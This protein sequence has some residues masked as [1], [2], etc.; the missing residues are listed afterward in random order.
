MKPRRV[1]RPLLL[2]LLWAYFAQGMTQV[3]RAAITFDEGPHL[4]IGYVTLRTGD[5]RLQPIHIHPPLANVLAAAPLLLQ[6]D[7][8]DPRQV[9]GW[10]IA[11]L[12][13][14]TDAIVWQ[15]AHPAHLA[16]AGRVPILLLG[17]LLGAFVIRWARELG[18]YRAALISAVGFAFD[19]NLIAHGAVI[20]TDMAVTLLS[21]ATLYVYHRW[22]GAMARSSRPSAL[23][24][25]AVGG[26]LGLAQLAKVSALL[27]IPVVGL[28]WLCDA[29]R[30]RRGPGAALVGELLLLGGAAFLVVWGGYRF[31]VVPV[32]GVPFSLPAGTHL[33]IYQSLEAH[34]AL[35]HPT[36]LA[37]RVGEYGW[38]QYFPVAFLLKT[39]LPVLLLGLLA[40]R[41]PFRPAP[42]LAWFPLLYVIS[43]LFSS[44]DIGYRHL[45]PVLPFLYVGLGVAWGREMPRL[46]RWGLLAASCW[47]IVGT[48]RTLPYPLTFFNELAG[49]PAGGY[50]YLV[51]SNLDW[52]QNLWDLA[53]W[54]QE[55]D[56]RRIAYAHYSPARPA[57]YGGRADFL[58]PDPR[59]VPF[60]PWDPS[61][62]WYAIG[63][64]VL[65]GPY[66]PSLN[67][68]AWFRSAAPITRLG[69]ALFI[70]R[71][72]DHPPLAWVSLCDGVPM[73]EDAALREVGHPV[74]RT[75]RLDCAH[76]QVAPAGG[77]SGL[78][79][80]PPDVPPP[81]RVARTVSL[82]NAAGQPSGKL[83]YVSGDAPRPDVVYPLHF[84]GPLDLLGVTLPQD[85]VRPGQLATL[86]TYWKVTSVPSRPLSLM[87]HLVSPAG[88]D[89]AVGDGLGFPIEQWRMGDVLVQRHTFT[90]PASA[91]PGR[92]T[93]RLGAYWLDTLARWNSPV[94]D[95]L[96]WG[97][98][99]VTTR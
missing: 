25:L 8:P 49:G 54:M 78:V 89:V 64:T 60:A 55:H 86:L 97:D 96:L 66:A 20:T 15:Y 75:V 7:L 42:T 2:V 51:D 50:R 99:R 27:L 83:Y 53:S 91:P 18:G 1:I 35:G 73:A 59:A 45:L 84:D 92:Y 30:L 56:V 76:S 93:F 13:A 81:V 40:L 82:R 36:F 22:Q 69:N 39:P 98:L 29:W 77:G 5:Y 48:L 47:L 44:V 87:A 57:T 70:Y 65:Q 71:V 14:E 67:T 3:R 9:D 34:Y 28:L 80:A 79:V 43:A 24:P 52:G 33:R 38:W 58:P 6:H 12:S 94:G 32:P 26:L 74:S 72:P 4:A 16:T 63:A 61:A 62:G 68:Y 95:S 31:Q 23:W 11:S 88:V 10:E 90:V 41:R 19:P 17:V 46:R 21:F 37:G 85:S